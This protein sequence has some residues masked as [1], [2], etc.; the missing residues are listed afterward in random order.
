VFKNKH[1]SEI[2]SSLAAASPTHRSSQR[3]W[4]RGSADKISHRAVTR[5]NPVYLKRILKIVFKNTHRS[6]NSMR[7]TSREA[8][9]SIG[10]FFNFNWLFWS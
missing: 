1:S 5:K 4:V 2:A 8:C 7:A 9:G 6:I 3:R 10:G